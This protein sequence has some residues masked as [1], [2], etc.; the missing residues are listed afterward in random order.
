MD[1]RNG[2]GSA[3]DAVDSVEYGGDAA[4]EA[5]DAEA[6]GGTSNREVEEEPEDERTEVHDGDDTKVQLPEGGY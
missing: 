3:D 1:E 6:S 5:A 4:D 2:G